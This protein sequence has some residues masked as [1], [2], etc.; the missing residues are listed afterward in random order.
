MLV[1]TGVFVLA[2]GLAPGRARADACGEARAWTAECSDALALVT[3]DPPFLVWSAEGLDVRLEWRRGRDEV[4]VVGEVPDLAA[5]PPRVAELQERIAACAEAGAPLPDDAEAAHPTHEP[6]HEPASE[7]DARPAPPVPWLALAA[8][9]CFG[10][11]LWRR[12]RALRVAFPRGTLAALSVLALARMALAQPPRFFQMNGQGP[13]WIEYAICGRSPYGPGYQ[14]LFGWVTGGADPEAG[15]FALQLVLVAA[16][17]PLAALLARGVGIRRSGALLFAG[18]LLLDP[19]LARLARSESYFG[20][21]TFLLFAAACAL[22]WRGRGRDPWLATATSGL[23][24]ALLARTHPVGWVAA[25][26]VPLVTALHPGRTRRRARRVVAHA[27]GIGVLVTGF[28]GHAM[29]ATL[30]G[31]VGAWTERARPPATVALWIAGAA[32][33]IALVA[34]WRG[35]GRRALASALAFAAVAIAAG[36]QLALT[37]WPPDMAHAVLRM[38]APV[39]GC[40]LFGLIQVGL[41]HA[42]TLRTLAHRTLAWSLVGAAL[43]GGALALP[44]PWAEVRTDAREQ[45][46]LLDQRE[47][48]G[49]L[50]IAHESHAGLRVVALPFYRCVPEHPRVVPGVRGA[51]LFYASSLCATDDGAAR[52]DTAERAGFTRVRASARFPAISHALQGYREDPVSVRLLAPAAARSPAA[53]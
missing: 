38:F 50:A 12:R 28:A 41:V 52:C 49:G 20:T 2:T 15:V 46:W 51:D 40:A 14:A 10:A 30:T 16:C 44:G 33:V 19:T 26:L 29:H 9:L 42:R 3:C 18:L 43:V 21:L 17:V 25:A 39:A 37:Y 7:P 24:V 35:L 22:A 6:A 8:L 13:L 27:A 53:P 4:L 1:T 31:P 36:W 11:L 5:L 34:R 48:L 47:D 23:F 32:I 45:A